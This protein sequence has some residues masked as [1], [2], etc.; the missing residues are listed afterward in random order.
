[1]TDSRAHIV[2]RKSCEAPTSGTRL[3]SVVDA[4][5]AIQPPLVEFSHDSPTQS[6]LATVSMI[7]KQARVQ[8][9]YQLI[10]NQCLIDSLK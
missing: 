4:R 6:G 2:P 9:V 10:Y 5:R 3:A 7:T 8:L 1:M